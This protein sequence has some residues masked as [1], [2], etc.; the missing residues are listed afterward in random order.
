[1][2]QWI[3]KSYIYRIEEIYKTFSYDD[4]IKEVIKISCRFP[5]I[6]EINKESDVLFEINN[7]IEKCN[8]VN[9]IS[10]SIILEEL[11]ILRKLLDF[12]IKKI[13]KIK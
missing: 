9:H 3:Y 2:E 11:Y 8:N 12:E 10:N 7:L 13:N 6:T 1:M 5:G 4:L